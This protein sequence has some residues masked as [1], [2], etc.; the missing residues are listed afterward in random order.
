[1]MAPPAREGPGAERDGTGKVDPKHLEHRVESLDVELDDD[2]SAAVV[3][4]GNEE[5]GDAV[6]VDLDAF[7][8]RGRRSGLGLRVHGSG[9]FLWGMTPL[10]DP[11]RGKMGD[12]APVSGRGTAPF[13]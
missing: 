3:V 7:L 6:R 1:M 9:S 11:E 5:P 4:T 2:L 12:G 13:G 10:V 8:A